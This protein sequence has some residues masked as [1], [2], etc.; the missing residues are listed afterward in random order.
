MASFPMVPLDEKLQFE[1]SNF[2]FII[3]LTVMSFTIFYYFKG[4]SLDTKSLFLV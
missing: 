1:D 2:V 3:L 4:G